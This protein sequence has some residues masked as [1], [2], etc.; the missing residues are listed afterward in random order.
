MHIIQSKWPFFLARVVF[1]FINVG[2]II[3]AKKLSLASK[4]RH[5]YMCIHFYPNWDGEGGMLAIWFFPFPPHLQC[6]GWLDR[7]YFLRTFFLPDAFVCILVFNQSGVFF[8]SKYEKLWSLQI[9]TKNQME[10]LRHGPLAAETKK[11]LKNIVNYCNGTKTNSIAADACKV[12][13]W[14]GRNCVC[15]S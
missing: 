10:G 2:W 6:L 5:M 12:V 3:Y 1:A 11:H 7:T 4:C 9:W 14:K 13:N 15:Q 8:Y